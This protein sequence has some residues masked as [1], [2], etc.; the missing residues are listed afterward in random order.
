M[1][2]GWQGR[3]VKHQ[4]GRTGRITQEWPGF[5]H[6]GLRIVCVD[7]TIAYVQ[8]NT[9]GRDTGEPGWAWWCENFSTGPRFL[10]LGDQGTLMIVN[11]DDGPAR[12]DRSLFIASEKG[13][14]QITKLLEEDAKS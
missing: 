14:D 13:W 6:V 4:D 3:L 11:P 12:R 10:P 5:C 2:L 9:N 8:L 1:T 7:E